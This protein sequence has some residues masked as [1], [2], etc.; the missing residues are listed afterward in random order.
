[1]NPVLLTEDLKT[2]HRDIDQQHEQIF[3]WANELLFGE[4][5][6]SA[7]EEL[8][9]ILQ[10]LFS[11]ANYHLAAEEWVMR[12]HDYPGARWHIEEHQQFRARIQAFVE[13][14]GREGMT[15]ELRLHLHGLV[16]E[17]LSDHIRDF[18]QAMAAF[19]REKQ[20]KEGSLPDLDD[21]M[22]PGAELS[23]WM[24]EALRDAGKGN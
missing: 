23:D 13:S 8:A 21:I 9:K 14:A 10:F 5:L 19:L 2:G 4:S 3:A 6:G 7:R 1:M 15:P 20:L 11:Y 18:D 16:A 17:W 12:E 24:R 22:E